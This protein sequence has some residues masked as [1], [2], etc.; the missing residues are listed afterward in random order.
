MEAIEKV[1]IIVTVK[2]EN[3]KIEYGIGFQDQREG[4]ETSGTTTLEIKIERIKGEE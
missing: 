3:Q 1:K 2:G 4:V